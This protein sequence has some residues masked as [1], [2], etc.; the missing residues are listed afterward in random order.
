MRSW[1]FSKFCL[2]HESFKKETLMSV[3]ILV[4]T[5]TP[6]TKKNKLN[7]M[8]PKCYGALFLCIK[9]SI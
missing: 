9:R 7:L 2:V 6:E 4:F 8:I 3:D 5:K 1:M